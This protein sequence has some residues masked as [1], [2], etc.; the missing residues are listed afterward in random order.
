VRLAVASVATV[1]MVPWLVSEN[2]QHSTDGARTVGVAAPAPNVAGIGAAALPGNARSTIETAASTGPGAGPVDPPAG[3]APVS[4]APVRATPSSTGPVSTTTRVDPT[5]IPLAP[6]AAPTTTTA[7]PTTAP[8]PTTTTTRAPLPRYRIVAGDSLTGIARRHGV[9]IDTLLALNGM[10]LD[11][12]ILPG[13][14]LLLPAGVSPKAAPTT[15][16]A[17]RTTTTV[18]RPP[19]SRTRP[20]PVQPS[21]PAGSTEDGK[22]TFVGYDNA[23]W[24]DRPC[25]HK[26]LPRGTVVTITNLDNGKSTTCVVRD[27]GP[28]YPGRIIDL[29]TEVF[30]ELAN[31]SIGVIPVRITW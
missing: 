6:A 14:T 8:R 12:L 28:F 21:V 2:Q 1:A 26:T 13:D 11:S 7:P 9:D 23:R 5:A 22:A 18:G 15:T 4:T 20:E 31:P 24:G 25:A 3:A 29:D 17:P 16:K 10:Q 27:R 19:T 30:A